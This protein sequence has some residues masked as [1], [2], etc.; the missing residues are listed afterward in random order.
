[1][2]AHSGGNAALTSWPIVQITKLQAA[3]RQLNAAI[4]IHFED[5]D[6]V[7]VSTLAGAAATIFSDLAETRGT[8]SW[9]RLAM[10]A[11]KI[12]Q[13]TYFKVMREAQNFFKH[14]ERDPDATLN[15]NP[16]DVESIMFG[17]IF[18]AGPIDGISTS[19]QV[20]QLWYVATRADMFPADFQH[21][22]AADELFPGIRDV[23]VQEQRHRGLLQLHAAHA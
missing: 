21:L 22:G 5:G 20:Y 7:V 23:P 1:M 10:D 12:D 19:E 13:R 4:R 15:L 3:H 8:R 14:A 17:A 11:N 2:N 9:D 16:H 18:T 6:P